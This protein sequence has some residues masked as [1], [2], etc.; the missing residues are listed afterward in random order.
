MEDVSLAHARDHL[1]ELMERASKG[2]DVR[3]T[4][5]R[6]GTMRLQP[7]AG[8]TQA[9]LPYP[10]RIFGQWRHLPEIPDDRLFAPLSEH[11]LKW[12]SG[13]QSGAK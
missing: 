9:T 11:E 2:E 6:L 13:E 4:D 1:E 8:S 12:L 5:P 10:P 7:V 3:I